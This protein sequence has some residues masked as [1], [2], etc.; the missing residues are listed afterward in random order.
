MKKNYLIIAFLCILGVIGLTSST[1]SENGKAGVTGSPSEVN[2]TDCHGDF[3]LNA[4][5]GSIV[6]T[7]SNMPGMAY[8]VG[9]TYHMTVTVSKLGMPL[10]GVGIECLTTSNQNAGTLIITD[11]ASTRIATKTVGG[12]S[13]KNMVHTMNGGLINDSKSFNFD[14]TAPSTNV[15]DVTFYFCGVAADRD[16]NE[17][18]D[19]VYDGS[20]T[21]PF[22]INTGIDSN[23]KS[24]T[25]LN[26]YPTIIT[27][28]VNVNYLLSKNEYVVIR[29]MDSMGNVIREISDGNKSSGSVSFDNLQGLSN[30]VYFI[31]LSYQNTKEVR[32]III[33]KK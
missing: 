24:K 10:F 2:C 6:L 14:W 26:V 22:N 8:E 17:S 19:Y 13:R 20:M 29:L 12:V 31:E 18:G 32:K 3:A 11:A 27:D 25:T 33:N 30:G 23:P 1:L 28:K 4:G 7:S 5:G 16:G 21:I 15:G 9:V